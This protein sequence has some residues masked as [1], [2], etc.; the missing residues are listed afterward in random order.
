MLAEL[1]A[2]GNQPKNVE[3]ILSSLIVEWGVRWTGL[4]KLSVPLADLAV[5]IV[6]DEYIMVAGPYL[7]KHID[8][9]VELSLDKVDL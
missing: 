9:L 5:K 7:Q 3:E 6:V 2:V 1:T 8:D 4:L